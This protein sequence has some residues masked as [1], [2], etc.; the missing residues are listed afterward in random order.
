MPQPLGN[1]AVCYAQHEWRGSRLIKLS[2]Q[3]VGERHPVTD[4]EDKEAMHYSFSIDAEADYSFCI[5]CQHSYLGQ[6][7]TLPFL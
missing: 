1:P 5:H 3:S 4:I 6:E 2:W 7:N